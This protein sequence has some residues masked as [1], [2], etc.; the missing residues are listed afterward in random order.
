MTTLGKKMADS[1][2]EERVADPS[3]RWYFSKEE[4]ANSPSRRQGVDPDKELSY[5]QQT[6]SMI[7]EMGHRLKL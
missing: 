1:R 6:A 3:A 4:L 7:H 2:L 5:R